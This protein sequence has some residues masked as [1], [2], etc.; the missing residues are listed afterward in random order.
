[1]ASP[2]VRRRDRIYLS[3]IVDR[4]SAS[5]SPLPLS[6]RSID[7][8][9]RLIRSELSQQVCPPLPASGVHATLIGPSAACQ[10]RLFLILCD[11]ATR[12]DSVDSLGFWNWTVVRRRMEER[13]LP[14]KDV[15]DHDTVRPTWSRAPTPALVPLSH[16]T[17][18]LQRNHIF[19]GDFPSFDD[20]SSRSRCFCYFDGAK[21]EK[22]SVTE[23]T[24]NPGSNLL[25]VT[26]MHARTHLGRGA[27]GRRLGWKEG[28]ITTPLA[29]I[30][31]LCHWHT[32]RGILYPYIASPP[33]SRHLADLGL[34]TV[35][36][37]Q[38]YCSIDIIIN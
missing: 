7:F 19:L 5:F 38:Q 28:T 13:H 24:T 26:H 34:H 35:T 20:G 4:A 2:S 3:R 1:M 25:F 18:P 22:G 30:K 33:V 6:D 11:C 16:S 27:W 23:P 21:E 12:T 31:L 9:V 15:H 37:D 29:P 10:P 32:R 36:S 17:P 14:S 8:Y